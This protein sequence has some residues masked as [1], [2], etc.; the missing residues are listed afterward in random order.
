M[1]LA[2]G[3][4]MLAGVGANAQQVAPSS[5]PPVRVASSQQALKPLKLGAALQAA[6]DNSPTLSS[7]RVITSNRAMHSAAH[8][9]ATTGPE[10]YP[11]RPERPR[12]APLA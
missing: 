10:V 3:L 7:T 6:L 12:W 1:S 2:L 9:S 8:S 11:A 4:S 5:A